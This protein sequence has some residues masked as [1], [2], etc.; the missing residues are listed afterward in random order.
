M[1]KH[2]ANLDEGQIINH[3]CH[4]PD[5]EK[6][7]LASYIIVELHTLYSPGCTVPRWEEDVGYVKLCCLSLNQRHDDFPGKIVLQGLAHMDSKE[8]TDNDF[9]WEIQS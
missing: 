9:Y 4:F 3:I 5:K 8:S 2:L 1:S 6:K 7:I